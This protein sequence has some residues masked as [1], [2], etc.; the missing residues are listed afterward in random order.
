MPRLAVPLSLFPLA[1]AAQKTNPPTLAEELR[2]ETPTNAACPDGWGCSPPQTISADGESVHGG[3]W[4][5]RIERQADSEGSFS[6]VTKTDSDGVQRDDAR[7]ARVHSVREREGRR[8]ILDAGGQS[9]GVS[10]F[11]SMQTGNPVKGTTPWAEYSISLPVSPEARTLV[12]GFL[13]S[14][15]GKAWAD[16]LQRNQPDPPGGA[17]NAG[18]IGRIPAARV[19]G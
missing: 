14:G 17:G 10:G 8:R 1:L 9:G 3:K 6:S 7:A 11:A 18:L 16:D 5:V 19:A 4:S 15:P 12:F 13:L 2:F